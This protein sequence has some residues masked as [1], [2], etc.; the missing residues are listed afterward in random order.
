MDAVITAGGRVGPPLADL[1]GTTVKAL[2]AVGGISML[3]RAIAAARGA[4][5]RRVAVIAGEEVAASCGHLIDQLVDESVSGA[6]NVRRALT[7]FGDTEFLYLTSDLP[8]VSAP[9]LRDFLD[10]VRPGAIGMAVADADAYEVRFPRAPAHATVVGGERIANGSAFL[11]P[12]GAARVIAV[13]GQQFFD[14]R[15]SLVQM[16]RLLGPALLLKFALRRL[17]IVDVER[18]AGQVLGF[19]AHAVR[20]CAPELCFDVDDLN[21][22]QFACAH[23]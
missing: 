3:E 19:A 23:A 1:I 8:F 17:R 10:R 12:A 21:D 16:A 5:A 22:Y 2:A 4:G 6:E 14:A 7:V 13:V 18:R 9:A 15:K 20:D 11:I